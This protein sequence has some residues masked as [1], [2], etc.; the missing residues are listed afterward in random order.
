MNR[1]KRRL[2]GG[3]TAVVMVIGGLG[4]IGAAA[5]P[6]GP[7]PRYTAGAEGAGDPYFPYAGNGGYD[8]QH[9]DV[10][11]AIS[12]NADQVYVALAGQQRAIAV[13]DATSLQTADIIPLKA[14]PTRLLAASI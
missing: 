3:V 11:L 4:T 12:P 8:V 10:D 9:Y 14:D 13:L 6:K 5:A 7:G 1:T 2:I